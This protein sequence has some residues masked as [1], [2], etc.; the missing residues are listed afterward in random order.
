MTTA[1]SGKATG[2]ANATG[3]GGTLIIGMTAGNIPYPDTPPDQGYE[4]R[5][6]VGYQIYDALA[7]FNLNQGKSVPTPHPG[8]AESWKVAADKLTWTFKLRQGVKFHG[9]TDFNADAVIFQMD[10]IMKKGSEF[11]SPLLFATNASNTLMIDSYRAVDP[12]TVEIKTKYPYSFLPWE[13]AFILMPSPT[14]IKKY[15]NKEYVK[16]PV[17]T[18]PFKVTKY[19]D[20]QI[21]ELVPNDQYWAGKPKLDKLILRPMPDPAARLAALES[22]GINWAEV[23]PPDSLDQLKGQGYQILLRTYPHTIILATN[24]YDPPFN[25]PKVR[26]ALQ[27]AVDR[28]QMCGDLLHD[29]CTPATQYMYKGSPW[30]DPAPAYNYQYDPKKAKQLLSEA[31]YP[32]GFTI[33]IAYPTSGSGNLWPQPM[34][35]FLQSNFKAVGVNM[36]LV[37]LEWNDIISLYRAGFGVKENQKYNG[38]YFSVA[39][40]APSSLLSFASW[41]IP[42]KGCCNPMGYQSAEVDKL[43]QQAQSEFDPTKQNELLKQAMDVVAKDSPVTFVVHDLDLRVLS[44]KVQGFVQPMSWFADLNH[45]WVQK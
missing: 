5:R 12:A 34:M 22:G 10:R 41:R 9:G 30:Y 43:L 23:P 4:G 7:R 36:K 8:L 37:P 27:Y 45:V 32:N 1:S 31:G 15:G 25:N 6:F 24:L 35:E 18:G 17:G 26:D 29:V 16:H 42:P 38:L 14:A 33:T 39:P 2:Q 21:M 11:F 28:N 20:G 40:I 3:S 13:M 44:P 19:V